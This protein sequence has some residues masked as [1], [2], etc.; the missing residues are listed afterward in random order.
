M[1]NV[2]MDGVVALEKS[3]QLI[4]STI[5]GIGNSKVVDN[6]LVI[7][8]NDGKT[9]VITFPVPKDGVSVTGINDKKNGTFTLTLSDNTESIPIT[10]PKGIKGDKLLFSDLTDSEKAQL[11]GNDGY[12]PTATI[13]K[14]GEKAIITI[15][16]KN[17]T[18]TATILDG[19]NGEGGSGTAED[20]LYENENFPDYTNVDSAL[21]ALFNK[22]YYIKPICSLKADKTGGIFEMGT[23]IS[24]PITFTWTTN[25]DILSQTLTGC[26]LA[27]SKI[28]TATYNLDVTSDKTFA[29][30]VSDGENSANSS[31]SYKFMNNVFWGSAAIQE[32]Y[33][34]TFINK[35]TNKKLTNS[36]KGN[37]GFNIANGEYGFWAIPSNM[38]ITTIWSGGF[39]ADVESVATISYTNSQGYT[40]DY[41]I[42]RTGKSGLGQISTEI[43]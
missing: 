15:T 19:K 36:I 10:L 18:T 30:L 1:S 12:S 26:A 17:G 11:Q 22:V 27:N 23:T 33:D 20:T 35:L 40:R 41:N 2:A 5:T 29:L 9:N 8:F 38:N 31:I 7:T 43:K 28:R 3:R 24:A 14:V 34:S 25:K 42:Y 13:K 16:D 21:N 37:Y 6:K 4:N 39:E 32:V